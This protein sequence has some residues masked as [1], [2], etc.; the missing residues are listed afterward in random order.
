MRAIGLGT[1][2][3]S[4]FIGLKGGLNA[5]QSQGATTGI[6]SMFA[7]IA[8]QQQQSAFRD[9][10][11]LLGQQSD[12][13]FEESLR[14]A[15]RI[16]RDA[17]SFREEQANRFASS[18]GTLEGSPLAVLAET[19]FLGQQESAAARRRGVAQAGLLSAQGLQMLRRGS[20]AAFSGFA[21]S[22]NQTSQSQM[23]SSQLRSQAFQAGLAGLGAGVQAAY[24]AGT[25]PTARRWFGASGSSQGTP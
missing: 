23:R 20:T 8:G 18:G 11:D 13:A 7:N 19:E 16:D 21:D 6:S 2:L 17:I 14:E 5:A 22:L 15:N 24:L 9:E 12:I 3:A 1:A 25:S 4:G 10:A